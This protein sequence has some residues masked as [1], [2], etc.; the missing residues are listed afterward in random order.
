MNN[1]RPTINRQR[2]R[3]LLRRLIDIYSPSGK[4][5][6]I[7]DYLHGY[8]KRHG[9]S[10]IRQPVDGDRHNLL[11]LPP[12]SDPFLVLIGHVD[13]VMAYELESFGYGEE[14]GLITG[15]GAADMKAGCA[16]MIEAYLSL[17]ENKDAW[18]NVALAMVVGEEE[19]GDGAQKLVEE[20]HFPWALIGEPTDMQPCLSHYGYMEIHI[21]ALGKRMHASL[22]NLG[23]NAIDNILRLILKLSHYLRE[24]RPEIV[25]NIRELSSTRAGFAVPDRCEAWLDLHLPPTSPVGEIT[26]EMDEMIVQ[27]REKDP[28]FNCLLRFATI[29][30]G[31]EIPDKGP[32]VEALKAAY[33][34][35]SLSWNPQ[36]FRSHSDAN[37][38]WAAGVKPILVGPGQLEKA[39]SPDEAV[40][41]EQVL[42][43]AQLYL[44]LILSLSGQN[45]PF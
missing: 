14:G 28:E 9:L 27:E 44:D 10:V 19:E 18:R 38:L 8:V 33:A 32:V 40:S 23:R 16:A 37:L 39:H 1:P 21:T 5:E 2:L 43:S 35:R 13:T 30:G 26:L 20:Y 41:F 34:G 12:D 29:H 17:V 7:C 24:Q 45:R 42:Q 3:R 31:F 22:A 4:E 11:I 15:L 6:E 36:A 25:F